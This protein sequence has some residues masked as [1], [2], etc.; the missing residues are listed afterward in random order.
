VYRI[1]MGV[2]FSD[3]EWKRALNR[4][5]QENQAEIDTIL[6]DFGVPLLDEENRPISATA[7][8]GR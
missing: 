7:G 5:I 3:Q 2:R 4:L 8:A 1:T 6:L